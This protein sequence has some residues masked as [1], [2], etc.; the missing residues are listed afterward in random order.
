MEVKIGFDTEKESIDDLKKLIAALQDLVDKREKST[1]LGNPLGSSSMSNPY[2]MR[3][4]TPQ[5]Q[6]T[7]VPANG[8]TSGGGRVVPYEDTSHLLSKLATGGRC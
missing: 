6:Q 4:Q 7:H 5:P 1:S 3:T 2:Q 8:Q